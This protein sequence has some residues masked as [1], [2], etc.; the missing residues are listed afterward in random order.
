MKNEDL[1]LEIIE[2]VAI[3]QDEMRDD[4]Q[5]IKIEQARLNGLVAVNTADLAE[6]KA[7]WKEHMA[8]TEHNESRL[9]LLEELVKSIKTLLKA[10]IWVA[11]SLG[12]LTLFFAEI[13]PFF[14]SLLNH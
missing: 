3:K 9:E 5:D 1:I 2:K 6:N 8:R 14:R 7:D 4:V 11:S 10:A 12:A 13:L